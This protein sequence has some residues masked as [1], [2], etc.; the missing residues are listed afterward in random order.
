MLLMHAA[1]RNRASN[2]SGHVDSARSG[3]KCM[4]NAQKQRRFC[5][6]PRYYRCS[7][8]ATMSDVDWGDDDD[9]LFGAVDL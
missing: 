4:Q 5:G 8:D 9:T 1:Q 6:Q 7:T 2:S 3:V